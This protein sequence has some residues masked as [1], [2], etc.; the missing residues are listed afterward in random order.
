MDQL[1]AIFPSADRGALI[2]ALNSHNG[3]VERTINYL[4]M[5]NESTNRER[6]TNM[7]NTAGGGF[8]PIVPLNS[9]YSAM[10]P[11]RMAAENTN[12]SANVNPTTADADSDLARIMQLEEDE[13]LARLLQDAEMRR[14][15]EW[16]P[17]T[18]ANQQQ[19]G[20]RDQDSWPLP[21]VSELSASIQ[22]YVVQAKQYSYQAYNSACDTLSGFYHEY[23]AGDSRPSSSYRRLTAAPAGERDSEGDSNAEVLRRGS[24]LHQSANL[25]HYEGTREDGSSARRRVAKTGNGRDKDE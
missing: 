12:E 17:A 3:D 5:E 11:P 25:T 9:A 6:A 2:S 13:R 4:L 20:W 18:R 7:T 14:Q 8:P 22:P 10:N 21:T 24:S 23:V 19:S 15:S 1:A 16:D